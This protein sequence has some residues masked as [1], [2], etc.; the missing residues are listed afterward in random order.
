ME[1]VDHAFRLAAGA[2]SMM[3]KRVVLADH[4]H[5]PLNLVGPLEV[6]VQLVLAHIF[7]GM[8]VPLSLA[9]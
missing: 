4:L 9:L 5:D 3:D 7:I 6:S 8:S 2:G 1:K